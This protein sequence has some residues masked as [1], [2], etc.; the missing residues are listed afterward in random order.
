MPLSATDL[1]RTLE[2][3]EGEVWGEPEFKSHVVEQSHMLRRVP[4]GSLS[5][6]HLRL[7]VGQQVGLPWVLERAVQVL[8]ANPLAEGDL[9]EGDLLA[10]VLSIPHHVLQRHPHLLERLWAV[11]ER[12]APSLQQRSSRDPWGAESEMLRSIA[13]LASARGAA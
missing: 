3:L 9:Y 5:I 4:L 10:A 7:L 11:V 6:E 2:E 8:E 13:R 12:A 1:A